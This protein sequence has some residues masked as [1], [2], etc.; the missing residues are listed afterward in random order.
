MAC[1]NLVVVLET[2]IAKYI[3]GKTTELVRVAVEL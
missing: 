1:G 3:E 2:E